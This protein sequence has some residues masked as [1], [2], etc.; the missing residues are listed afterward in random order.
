MDEKQLS[1]DIVGLAGA[2]SYALDCI[3]AEL[4][5]ITNK[6]GKR[7]AYMSVCMAK[8]WNVENDA[9]QDLA[10]CA[11]LHD[12]ALTQYITEEVKK[13][14]G[15]DIKKDFLNE[16]V[17][18]HCVYGENNIA[19]IPFKTNVSNVI[20]YHHELANGKGPFKKAWQEVP[21]FARIIHLADVIDAI[22]NNIK[23][24]QEKW[25]KCCEFLV[26]QKGLLFDDECVEAFLE[27]ISKETFVSL[28]DGTFE[29]KLWEIVPRKKQMFDWN[30]CKNIAD[31]FA[32]IVDYKSPFTSRHSIGVA[33]KA[34]QYAKYIGYDVLDIEKM[35]LAG[36]LHDIGK[37]AVGNEIL[38][39]PDKLTDEEFDKMK[40]HA[41]YTYLMLSQVDGF[42]D[43][44]DWAA[45]HHEKLNGK[46]YPFG[47]TADELN[48]QERIMACVDIYQ[49]LTEELCAKP[50]QTLFIP[51]GSGS[52]GQMAV[53]IAK[54]LGL[55]VIVSGN[56]RAKDALLSA[57]ADRYIVCTE[58][59]Y[60]QPLSGVDFIIDTLGENE[61]DHELSV[62]K[63]NG[64]LLSLRGMPNGAFAQKNGF[65]LIK[66]LL[67]TLAG[68]NY[69]RKARRQ[70]KAYRFL[71]VRADGAQLEKI[72]RI[73]AANH[74]VPQI[75][76][77][78]FDLS[79]I[80]DALQLVAGGRINGKVI[81]RFP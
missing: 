63:E 30:T 52:F 71:F 57:G 54:A 47:K 33:E 78:E 45:L 20:L 1:I 42:E 7:V 77:R 55:R 34:A 81:V 73:V 14:P 10:I 76:S 26:R 50:G 24:R 80:N 11:L 9:L 2:Y 23:F 68:A 62:L 60:W 49:A 3:E 17:N 69:A 25:D 67:F 4:V 13:N 53:P 61:F 32:N 18:L 58:E 66:R 37:M 22:A 64:I 51:G 35:Y 41:G 29:S 39:K 48:E 38:E 65:P 72:T 36:A 19:K 28:E 27:M 74:I 15:I 79:Q 43:I 46:G 44:R 6:H 40:N 5:N 12:N 70:G 21:L 59:N 8:Y 75:D 16:K 31:F 56:A